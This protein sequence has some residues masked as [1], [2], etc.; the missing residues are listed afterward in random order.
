MIDAF[1]L[2][3]FAFARAIN[4]FALVIDP[5]PVKCGS[6]RC[7]YACCQLFHAF[8][9]YVGRP[10]IEGFP[11]TCAQA[12]CTILAVVCNCVVWNSVPKERAKFGYVSFFRCTC[13]M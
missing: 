10:S 11:M 7:K 4:P 5:F 2:L 6:T 12:F 3:I 1:T 8:A 13:H 9:D